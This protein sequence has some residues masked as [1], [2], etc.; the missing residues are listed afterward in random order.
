MDPIDHIVYVVSDLETGVNYFES[1]TGATIIIGGKHKNKG[2]H[3]AIFRIGE[4]AYFEILAPD[5]ERN[6]EID[7]SWLGTNNT[8]IQ[9]IS[10]WCVSYP[11]MK[12]GLAFLNH[13]SKFKYDIEKGSR[14]KSD[15]NLLEWQLGISDVSKET[16]VFPFLIDWGSSIHPAHALAHECQ[17]EKLILS[18]SCPVK[19]QKVVEF[20]KVNAKVNSSI[21]P[22]I[23]LI[24]NTPKGLVEIQ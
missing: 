5:P 10:R 11:E 7:V 24:L 2:T 9:R 13:E 15:G 8:K 18:H 23:K 22:K 19:V 21:E 4:N 14:V 20:F 3:N 6:P 16:D 1:I 12:K 17:I